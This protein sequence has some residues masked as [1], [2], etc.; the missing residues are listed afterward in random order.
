LKE[1][2][3]YTPLFESRKF[4]QG[5]MLLAPKSMFLEKI[6]MNGKKIPRF[7]FVGAK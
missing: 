2:V 1:S 6:V 7:R 3:V 4:K 5:R